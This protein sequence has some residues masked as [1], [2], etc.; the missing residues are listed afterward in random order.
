[1]LD[2]FRKSSRSTLIYV[3]FGILIAVFLFTFNTGGPVQEGQS[4]EVMAEVAGTNIDTRELSLAMSLTPD[5]APLGATGY[6]KMQAETRYAG[7]RL[8][9]SGVA[10]E[11]AVF[12]SFE[13]GPPPSKLEK[14]LEELIESVL[15]A[16]EAHKQG[17]G[18]S[19]KELARRVLALEKV[20]GDSLTDDN[21]A[22]DPRKYEIFVRRRLETSKSGLEQFL[23]REILRDKMVQ[24][25]TGGV[26]VSPA[27]IASLEAADT[28]RP[29]FE[30]VSLDADTAASA[31][32]IADADA[33]AW[34]PAH[35]EDLKKAYDAKGEAYVVQAKYNV[36]GI[37]ASSKEA[38]QAIRADLDKAWNGEV[39][40][41]A[42]AAAPAVEGEA[43][44]PAG[45]PKKAG[46]ITDAADK[47]ARLL[48]FF[49]KVATEKTEHAITKDS[50]GKFVDDLG[51]EGLERMPFG[52]AVAEA[53]SAAAEG[54]LV[55]PVEGKQGFWVLAVEK[56]IEGSV[57]P[58]ETVQRELA[59]EILQKE[60][61]GAELE[62]LA[63]S[64]LAAAKA[65]PKKALTD[66]AKAW[67]K[68]R[69]GKE[70]G[71]LVA[72]E[73]G[74]I[75]KSPLDALQGDMEAMLGLPPRADDP[76]DIPGMGKM[77]ELAPLAYKLTA[78]APVP[79]KVFKSEDGKTYY[80]ARLAGEKN[81]ADAKV[82]AEKRRESLGRQLLFVRKT[83]AWRAYVGALFA[84]AEK[85][86]DLTRT[87]AFNAAVQADRTRKAEELKKLPGAAP[88]PAPAAGE[89]M[90]IEFKI[91]EKA[92][93]APA[94]KPSE[95]AGDGQKK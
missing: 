31:V 77:P 73:S 75:G 56:K 8:P 35:A 44:A 46:E 24:I 2:I 84:Q 72:A 27:E 22:I 59:K 49:S 5:P 85:A 52:P 6:E 18:V 80:V 23:R 9:F 26:T 51:K 83:E 15:V 76:N 62:N 88:A 65:D 20:F 86:G 53:V 69:T 11:L 3:L 1:M 14:V 55:G 70:D 93:A 81:D 7:M 29:R 64:V 28:K 60:R 30:F 50:G 25:V 90:P 95:P 12:T 68:T 37:Q 43:A 61:A 57:K 67:N 38:A 63:K 82:A 34:I 19:D 78:A 4:V 58:I 87:E 94:A 40:L 54:T 13:N 92:P 33:D 47:A 41:D 42:V 89:P 79:D 16:R 21:G 17:L 10:P 66:V 71:P 74:A 32:E 91:N 45:E 48:Q 39:A 36:R